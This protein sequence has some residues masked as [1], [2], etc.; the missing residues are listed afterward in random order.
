MKKKTKQ[1]KNVI[2]QNLKS[3]KKKNA[4]APNLAFLQGLFTGDA[5]T[6]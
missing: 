4:K 1:N 2:L 6:T 5:M 3:F